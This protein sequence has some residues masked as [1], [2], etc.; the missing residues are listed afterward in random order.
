MKITPLFFNTYLQPFLTLSVGCIEFGAC[1]NSLSS[2]NANIPKAC[3]F[4]LVSVVIS[5]LSSTSFVLVSVVLVS[6]VS[7]VLVSS[8]GGFCSFLI[9]SSSSF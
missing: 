9:S 1:F 4:L 6:G 5:G 7:S 2:S 8:V 3:L